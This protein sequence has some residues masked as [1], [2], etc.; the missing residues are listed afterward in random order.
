MSKP[1]DIIEASQTKDIVNA[2]MFEMP[3]PKGMNKKEKASN[4]SS[5]EAKK[6]KEGEIKE[7]KIIN[8]EIM[9]E[10]ELDEEF[11]DDPEETENPGYKRG[12]DGWDL[13][14]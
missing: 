4:K 9:N 11:S 13:N 5:G 2:F 7:S 3:N 12:N 6:A 10:N 8:E 14:S 1:N